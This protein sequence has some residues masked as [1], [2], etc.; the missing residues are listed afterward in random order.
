VLSAGD[1]DDVGPRGLLLAV[2]PDHGRLVAQDGCRLVDVERLALREVRDDVD[3]DDVGVVAARELTR[4]RGADVPGTDDGDLLAHQLP[5]LSMIA[6][7]YSAVPTALG[8][9]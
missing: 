5:S 6:S 4:A 2:R 3:E 1:H 8:S 7:A 9:S